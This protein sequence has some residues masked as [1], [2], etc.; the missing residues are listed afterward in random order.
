MEIWLTAMMSCWNPWWRQRR[1]RLQRGQRQGNARGPDTPIVS[2]VSVIPAPCTCPPFFRADR[3][4]YQFFLKNRS[5]DRL[6]IIDTFN[7]FMDQFFLSRTPYY[8]IVSFCSKFLFQFFI[9]HICVI[10]EQWWG[11]AS[12]FETFLHKLFVKMRYST[13]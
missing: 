2:L 10:V 11:F 4:I 6:F 7:V 13:L 5:F 12:C 3:F 8:F 1:K 9:H